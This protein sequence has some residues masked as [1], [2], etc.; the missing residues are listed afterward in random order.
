MSYV[1]S[2][3]GSTRVGQNVSWSDI[4]PMS[5]G[6]SKSLQI[7]AHI[8]GPMSG[9]KNLTNYVDVSGQPEH[10]QN[11]TANASADVQAQ[12]AK[13]SV[14]KTANPTFGSPSTNV[15]F[16]L[17]V[18]NTG[19]ASLPHVS[20]SDLLPDGMSYV[21]SS[22]GST[23][24]GQH[25]YWSDIGPM[26]SGSSKSLQI[27]AHIDGPISGTKNLTNYVDVSGQPEHGQNVTANASADVQA[28]EAKISVSK[29]ADP[30][31]GS[32]STNVTFTLLVEN[33]GSSSLP[34][35]S[36][37][38]LLPDRH[39][40]RLVFIG[41]HPSRPACLLVRH[42]SHVIRLQQIAADRSPYRRPHFR[43][44]KSDQLRGRFRP[45][46]ARP[47]CHSQCLRRRS[48][49]GSQDICQQDR[50]SHF[51]LTEHQRH[52]HTARR[53]YGQRFSAACLRQRSS[54]GPA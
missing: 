1:S 28:Q 53:E 38:D 43:H 29:T 51:R 14:S 45:T 34:H 13:I 36:V 25:V 2:S 24:V 19:S 10:G 17:L 50:R 49:P 7:V 8:D 27:V 35:V 41:Q 16:T 31:F 40:L 52:L 23:R 12:E 44:Q 48:G 15:T 46:R 5:S 42:R 30:T 26:S 37:S 54:A 11:V 21:S 6:S 4:G 9:T 22:S 20:V 39:E 18:K 33:T 47:E 32:P 3:S